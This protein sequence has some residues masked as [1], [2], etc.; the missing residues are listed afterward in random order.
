MAEAQTEDVEDAIPGSFLRGR[1][2][3]PERC[4][5]LAGDLHFKRLLNGGK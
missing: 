2:G 3:G 5:H 1:K 4:L